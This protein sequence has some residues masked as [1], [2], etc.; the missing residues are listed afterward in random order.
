MIVLI[1]VSPFS[2][3]ERASVGIPPRGEQLRNTYLPFVAHLTCRGSG[4]PGG[5][6]AKRRKDGDS[7][8]P[9]GMNH[10]TN[11]L[12]TRKAKDGSPLESG[13][14]QEKRAGKAS[15]RR[16][17]EGA[18][19][20]LWMARRTAGRQNPRTPRCR[21]AAAGRQDHLPRSGLRTVCLFSGVSGSF[22]QALERAVCGIIFC[23]EE[24]D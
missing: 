3:P 11:T 21:R 19:A 10:G 5:D 12:K 7:A 20:A 6:A 14:V 8:P 4:F 18:G 16:R 22:A 1:W 17:S 24:V 9:L 13:G 23:H 15:L 2:S